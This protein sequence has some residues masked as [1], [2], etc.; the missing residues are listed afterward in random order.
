M[1]PSVC[2]IGSFMMDLALRAPRRPVAGE[3]IVGTD[4]TMFLGGK[5][6]NQAVAASRA[7]ARTTMIGRLGRD[8]FGRRFLEC[9]QAEGIDCTHVVSDSGEGTGIGIPLTEASGENSIVIVPRAN[10][11]L[12]PDDVERAA[13]SITGSAVLV[14]QMELPLESMLTAA[15]I[16]RRAGTFVVLNPA[17]APDPH[18]IERFRGLVDLLV[19]NEVEARTLCGTTPDTAA[20][21]AAELASLLGASVV[22]TTGGHGCVVATGGCTFGVAAHDVPLVDTVGAG[23]AFCGALAAWISA[24]TSLDEAV[25]YANA[26]GALA[27]T[28]AGAEPAMPTRQA[29]VNLAAEAGKITVAATA[30]D[31]SV[32]PEEEAACS[33]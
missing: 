19:P 24:G 32:T 4:F 15:R 3:T 25:V 13:A 23:D 7:G 12:S 10:A 6:F 30:R 17:P 26:A 1:T 8:D 31:R 14:M 2:V 22:M 33:R 5:G 29:I 9:L 18:V 21:V 27:V 28:R 20:G 11:R 16:A